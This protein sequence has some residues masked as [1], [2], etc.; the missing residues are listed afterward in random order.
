MQVLE[1]HRVRVRIA[2]VAVALVLTAVSVRSWKS[3]AAPGAPEIPV[4]HAAGVVVENHRALRVSGSIEALRSV[5]LLAPRVLGSRSG[6]N[7]GGDAGFGGGNDFNLVLLSIAK[8]GTHVEEGSI[9]A[10][11]DPTNQLLRLDDYK[12]AVVQL[13][14]QR[15]SAEA[16]LAATVEAQAQAVRSAKADWDKAVLDLQTSPVVS[17]IDKEKMQLAVK[18]AEE[19]YHELEAETAK[20]EES[21]R[22][23][24]RMM[25]LNL[26]QSKIEQK[27]AENNVERMAVKTPISGYVVM[28]SIVR[29]GEYGQVREGD[30][31]FAGQPVV[32]V[33]D[34]SSMILDGKLNQVDAARLRLGMKAKVRLDAY[35]DLELSGTVTGIGAMAVASSFRAAY[36][37]ETPIRVRIEGTDPRLL[38]DLTGS[39][40]IALEN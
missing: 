7:R 31:V 11:F 22:A 5:S 14:G 13:E 1:A 17:D 16:S 27:R 30:Q 4:A 33:V 24:L 20:V 39:A 23:Q 6:F 29:N 26:A 37:G 12:D 2:G 15:R 10:Q 21:Q 25:E 9:V 35:P 19:T 3:H 40:E 8:P 28:A 34:T 32:S 36:V 38:P 18:Q